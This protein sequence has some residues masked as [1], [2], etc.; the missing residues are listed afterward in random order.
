VKV[1]VS[2]FT[3]GLTWTMDYV[4]VADPEEEAMHFTGYVRVYNRS[5]EE[6]EDAEVRLIVGN[7]HLVE[8]IAD[9][10]RQR[11]LPAPALDSMEGIA[12]RRDAA[13]ASFAEAERM[14]RVQEA[15]KQIV[16]EGISEYF[17]FSVSGEETIANGWS[18][19][20]LAVESER[21]K[22]D[23]RYRLRVHQY[24]PRPVRFFVWKNDADHGLGESPLPDG[25]VR[26]FRDNGRDG[27]SFLGQQ[28]IRY[29][30][31]KADIEIN[32]GPDDLVVYERRKAKVERRN[33][34]FRN[35]H[36]VGWDEDTQWVGTI[37][38]YR[39]K[40]IRFELH[41]Q[42]P[43]HVEFSSELPTRLFDYQTVLADFD[44]AARGRTPYP[45]TV[46]TRY[47]TRATQS[48]VFL[49]D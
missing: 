18:K 27:L 33:F 34:Q 21:T 26:V 40:P 45:F 8:K 17:M 1:E 48:K 28:L 15:P 16:K 42:W 14:M 22:F 6:Y 38:N 39:T 12:L 9:L 11:G 46:V 43:G 19:R 30:P 10:A 47:G 13:K 3:S 2:Y 25:L 41:R 24:G 5:G 31:A 4:S 20:M 37:R 7:I 23:I 44:V 36:V 32:L 29:V 35:G 49:A